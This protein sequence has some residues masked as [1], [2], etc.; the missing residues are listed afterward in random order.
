MDP[1]ARDCFFP[2]AEAES[3]SALWPSSSISL[4]LRFR[5]SAAGAM[6]FSSLT[7]APEL[8]G[9]VVN[10]NSHDA[11]LF[12]P[13]ADILAASIPHPTFPP[14]TCAARSATRETLYSRP[15]IGVSLDSTT[16]ESPDRPGLIAG[17]CGFPKF[18]KRDAL[19]ASARLPG[20][21]GGRGAADED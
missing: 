20:G 8:H 21:I 12:P 18:W 11:V 10:V 9:D 6:D 17:R 3:A 14:G 1:E 13:A 4:P 7:L 5:S 19:S 15:T 16:V 2:S